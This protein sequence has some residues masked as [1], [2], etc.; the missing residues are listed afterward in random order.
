MRR[1]IRKNFRAVAV[2]SGAVIAVSVST[3]L[4]VLA[5]IRIH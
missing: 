5:D 2:T 3:G 1:F 4:S